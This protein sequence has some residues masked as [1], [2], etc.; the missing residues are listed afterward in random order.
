MTEASRTRGPGPRR[1]AT[2]RAQDAAWFLDRLVPGA[3]AHTVTRAYLVTGD[4]DLGALGA[5]WREV[6]RRHEILRTTLVEDAGRPVQEIAGHEAVPT[7]A[8][9]ATSFADLG[10]SYPHLDAPGPDAGPAAAAGPEAA[11]R[12]W[13]AELASAPFD[14]AAGPLARLGVARLGA[15]RHVVAFVLHQAVAD[16]GSVAILV[17]EIS[18]LYA[19][20]VGGRPLAEALPPLTLQY[21]DFAARQ[22]EHAATPEFR[23]LLGWWISALTPLPATPPLPADRARP[24]G[25]SPLGGA[26]R[27]DW[28]E[29]ITRGVGALCRDTG[30]T[31][32][33]VLL[34]AFHTLLHRYGGEDRAAVGVPVTARPEAGF[35]GLIGCF[36]NQIVLP[37]DLSGLPSFRELVGRVDGAARAAAE[38]R[39]LPFDELV[40]ALNPDRDPDRIPLSDVLF[41]YRD[42]PEPELRLPRVAVRRLEA[43]GGPAVADLTLRVD[44]VSPSVAGAL[45]YRASLFD[46]ASARQILAQLHT[47]LAAGLRDPG[48][49]VDA[50]PLENEDRVAAA[51]READ[52]IGEATTGEPPVHELVHL[53]ARERPAAA[54]VVWDGGVTSYRDV[55][56][57]AK[58]VTRALRAGGG[59]EGLPVAVR[60]SQGP[61]QVATLIGVLDAG[62][63]LVCLGTGD[64]G[65]RGK[66]ILDDVRPAWLVLDGD[67]EGD[68]LARWYRE[69]LHGRILD[70]ALL[71][72]DDGPPP[73]P[74]HRGPAERAYVAYTSG[75]TGRPK[76]IAQTHGSLAQFVT[77]FGAEFCIGRDSRVAQWAAPGYDASL[78][79]I[80][81]ALVAGATLLPVPDRVRANPE[82]MA[83]WLAAERITHFQTVPSFARQLLGVVEARGSAEELDA[84]G[85]LLLAGEPLPGELANGLRTALPSA[86]LVN[87][88]G[89]TES[90]L[91]TWHDVAAPVYGTVPVGRP[92][93][94]RQVLVV[95]EHDRPCPAGVPGQLVIRGPH[96]TPGYVGAAAVDT[97]P[98]RPLPGF[99]EEHRTYRTGD[100]GRRRWDG[101][102]EFGGRRDFQ[103]K[104]NGSRVELTD[105]EA[106][107]AA[108]ESVAECAV[109][110]VADRDGLVIRLV[111][112]VV[113]RPAPD[114][115]EQQA[116][117]DAWRAALRRR[118]G[119]GMLPVSFK[120]LEELPRNVGGK[121][122]RRALPVPPASRARA[123]RTVRT[124]VEQDMAEIWTRLMGPGASDADASFFSTGG[125]SL[126][127]PLLLD[128]IRDRFGV[129]VSIR[130]FFADPTLS[131]L[132]TL[133]ESQAIP[134]DAVTPTT[135]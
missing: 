122:D 3:P 118:F 77:W 46:Q 69:E 21:A 72:P 7:F 64:A 4:L 22:R 95:D 119:K 27:F 88:Y 56:R 109:V 17:E 35:E 114:G 89:P 38:H 30:A 101:L 55:E 10:A 98:F 94:G 120:V 85:H 127:I 97:A 131:G 25:P 34:A 19:A 1:A 102:L 58:A 49:P 81:A 93:P 75:S 29:E 108:H 15:S 14:L 52:L 134:T 6:V 100:M 83:D 57:R 16:D 18:A 60:M 84:L 37:G 76:G 65:E 23:D 129:A 103:I 39:E 45:E 20:A 125:H 130:A 63:H 117:P 42:A 13:C 67:A 62:A 91:A 135:R 33:A 116:T 59:V 44:R 26:L 121:V 74:A 51:V 104:F 73:A 111:A 9:L 50:L 124:P 8:D 24:A 107:L 99:G 2:S 40:R 96:I 70:I 78:V 92:I 115:A 87:L 90:I 123:A 133:I 71:D 47:L 86:R 112:F 43:A 113:P 126:L 106:A 11:A 36:G 31:P 68:E 66:I 80:F 41:V 28:G 5:A 48:L 12:R 61:R 105:I 110:A 128:R 79:E 82:R 54:A 32:F 132:S 53:R